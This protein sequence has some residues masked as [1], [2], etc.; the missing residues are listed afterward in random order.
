MLPSS[1]MSTAFDD[2]EPPSRPITPRTTWPGSSVA[3]ARSA[4]SCTSRG[5]RR[6]RSSSSTSGGPGRSRR[7]C[8]LRPSVDE[9]LERIEAAVARRRRPA[10]GG[11]TAPRRTRRRYCAFFGTKISSSIGTSCRLLVAARRPTPPGCAGAST[12][13]GTAG[14]CSDRRAAAPCGLSVLPRVSTDE[15][16]ADDR[17]GQRAHD[18]VARDAATSRG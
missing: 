6:A 1:S 12:P 3:S 7:A 11:R 18:L 2:V 9:L 17:V 5:T 14:T 10:R 15:V 16:L 4:G 8:A 13:G